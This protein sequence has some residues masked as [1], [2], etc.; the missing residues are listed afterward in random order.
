MKIKYLI[1]M[2]NA[3]L[4]FLLLFAALAPFIL[5]GPGFAVIFWR[6]AWPLALLIVLALAGLNAFFISNYPVYRLLEREDWPALAYYLEDKVYEKKQYSLR[7]VRLLAN[8]YL[9]LCDFP[10]AFK[11]ESKVAIVKPSIVAKN[12]LIFGTARLLSGDYKR[13]A[14]FYKNCLARGKVPQKQWVLWFYA[15]SLMLEGDIENAQKQFVAL[16]ENSKDLVVT[17]L[18]AYF[19]ASAL[20]KKSPRPEECRE[21]YEK[22]RM[23][24]RAAYKNIDNWKKETQKAKAEVHRAVIRKYINEAGT[25][26]FEQK[27]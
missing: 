21:V 17:G 12:V 1:I 13:A 15:L 2:F 18:S 27:Q 8:S 20:E 11:L 6:E 10:S 26:L 25:W 14:A 9:E 3:I 22:C 24:V 19:L 23:R 7:N 5:I 16:A 4:V